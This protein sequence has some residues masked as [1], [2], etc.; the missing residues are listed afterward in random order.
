MKTSLNNHKTE[1]WKSDVTDSIEFYNNWFLHFAPQTYMSERNEATKK[2]EKAFRLTQDLTS[3]SAPIIKEN[4]SLLHIFRM[5]TAPPIARDRLSGLAYI[6]KSVV[7][8]LEDGLLPR[9]NDDD[10][11]AEQLSRVISVISEGIDWVWE[12]RIHDFDTLFK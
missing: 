10:I 5:L 1:Q 8:R 6:P 9:G 3:I 7:E 12:H 4:P 2:V 11:L